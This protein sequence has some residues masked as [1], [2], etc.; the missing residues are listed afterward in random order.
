M[1]R[2]PITDDYHEG[3]RALA[4]RE[5]ASPPDATVRYEAAPECFGHTRTR[6]D[7]AFRD[8]GHDAGYLVCCSGFG[9]TGKSTF[10]ASLVERWRREVGPA[11][12]LPSRA[13]EVRARYRH[14]PPEELQRLIAA[15]HMHA[16]RF[17]LYEPVYDG[18]TLIVADRWWGDTDAYAEA[19]GWLP[20]SR[21]RYM[22]DIIFDF[23]DV[24]D[25]DDP[26]RSAFV[27]LQAAFED[28]RRTLLAG[29][30]PLRVLR[31]RTVP[32]AASEGGACGK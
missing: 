29:W 10:A 20:E 28:R 4:A 18:P 7:E 17:A 21:A 6:F 30:A 32:M 1:S 8:G 13:A 5:A 22:A 31:G 15:D 14:L 26:R 11:I 24:H 23:V 16:V 9:G 12:Y 2:Y 25:R 27:P 3:L 19:N